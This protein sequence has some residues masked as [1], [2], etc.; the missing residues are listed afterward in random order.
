MT[1]ELTEAIYHEKQYGSMCG[2]HC[3]NNLLQGPYFGPDDLAEIAAELDALERH[4]ME[5]GGAT[6]TSNNVDDS[7]NFSIQVLS[8]ALDRSHGLKLVQ[9]RR[10][11]NELLEYLNGDNADLS[12]DVAFVCNLANHWFSIRS[13]R[14]ELWDLNSLK[15][16]PA[17]I[18]LFYLSAYLGQLREEG[19]SIFVVEGTLP[20][21]FTDMNAMGKRSDWFVPGVD[22]VGVDDSAPQ[23][24]NPD[25][26][27]DPDLRAA[28]RASMASSSSY[29]N[30]STAATAGER[31]SVGAFDS[32][33]E[34]DS[35]LQAALAMSMHNRGST[36]ENAAHVELDAEDFDDADDADDADD[37]EELVRRAIEE[38]LKDSR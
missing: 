31:Y 7:G 4:L 25:D 28:L 8:T 33:E 20:P 17:C 24:L 38:S 32:L 14:G 30:H 23:R 6:S 12:E 3:L 13:I 2:Q 11:V 34:S 15:K 1:D 18:S 5:D 19:Y 21:L 26:V 35:D 36:H 29:G 27:D 16:R 22:D 9:D 10:A 37:E